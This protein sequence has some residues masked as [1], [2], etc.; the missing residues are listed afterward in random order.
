MTNK[1]QAP[2]WHALAT[3]DWF[4]FY[5]QFMYASGFKNWRKS[6]TSL[7]T[8]WKMAA[9]MLL[10]AGSAVLALRLNPCVHDKAGKNIM[11]SLGKHK[12]L[13]EIFNQYHDM[14]KSSSVIKCST[15]VKGG[16]FFE[17]EGKQIPVLYEILGV[18]IKTTSLIYL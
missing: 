15:A 13:D 10:N 16:E 14:S 17:V 1:N 4:T 6:V 5:V 7:K 9:S 12:Y 3:R 8:S 11:T 18:I 2:R